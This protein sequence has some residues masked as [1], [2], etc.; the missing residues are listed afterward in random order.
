MKTIS[1]VSSKTTIQMYISKIFNGSMWQV[2]QLLRAFILLCEWT[3]CYVKTHEMHAYE[4]H[5]LT[6]SRM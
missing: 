2:F 3:Q 4:H 6:F 1:I 5:Y